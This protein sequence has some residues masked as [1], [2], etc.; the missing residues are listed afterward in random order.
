M[1]LWANEY[2]ILFEFNSHMKKTDYGL[3]LSFETCTLQGKK[4]FIFVYYELSVKGDLGN[5]SG[6]SPLLWSHPFC[7]AL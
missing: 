2:F 7:S 6:S 1:N 3:R 5:V 4:L